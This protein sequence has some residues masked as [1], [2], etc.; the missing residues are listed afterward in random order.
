MIDSKHTTL[1]G[2]AVSTLVIHD[3]SLPVLGILNV[4]GAATLW[5]TVAGQG[6]VPGDPVA[7]ADDTIRVPAGVMRE[8]PVPSGWSQVTIKILGNNNDVTVER[9]L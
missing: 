3:S 7:N 5:C 4:S 1:T 9:H 2:T 6:T 8:Y